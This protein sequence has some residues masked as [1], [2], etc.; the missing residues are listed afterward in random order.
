MERGE[1]RER[2]KFHLIRYTLHLS[3]V[4]TVQVIVEIRTYETKF[5]EIPLWLNF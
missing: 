1:V 2:E 5:V 3:S 4:T